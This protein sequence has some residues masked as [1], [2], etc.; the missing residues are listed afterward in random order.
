ME[1]F[2]VS[3]TS[4]CRGNGKHS[5]GAAA[6]FNSKVKPKIDMER[7]CINRSDVKRS[8]FRKTEM[9]SYSKGKSSSR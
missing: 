2:S 8:E 5:G 1:Q 3:E 9:A 4:F 7:E 6:Q